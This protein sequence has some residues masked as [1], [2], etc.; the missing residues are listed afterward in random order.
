MGRTCNNRGGR[1]SLCPALWH[2][3]PKA[4]KSVIPMVRDEFPRFPSHLR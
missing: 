4:I 1:R 3:K 2:F